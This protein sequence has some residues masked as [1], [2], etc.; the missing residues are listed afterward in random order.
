MDIIKIKDLEVFG[1]HGVYKEE[2]ILGQKF[3]ISVDLYG[4]LSEAARFDDIESSVN[5]GE[6]C[7]FIKEET[8][9]NTFKLIESL[10][11]HLATNILLKYTKIRKVQVEVKKPWAPVLMPLDTVSIVMERKWHKVYLSIG[12]NM[13]NKEKNLK[14]AIALLEKDKYTKVK[15]ISSFIITSP[16]GDVIQDDFLNG[17]LSIET[18]RNPKELLDL[19]K[20]IEATLKRER[21]LRWGPRTI[22]LDILF[23]D[24]EIIAR[25]DLTIPHIELENRMFVLEPMVEIAPYVKHPISGKSI[26]QLYKEKSN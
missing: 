14:E 12:S 8:Q 10:T 1:N 19:I 21:T 2:N 22:D 17:A 5:Y 20:E 3:L 26:E 16:V 15:K 25:K 23:Y 9:K 24:D 13:G 6:V 11:Q 7:Q 18:L 4:D